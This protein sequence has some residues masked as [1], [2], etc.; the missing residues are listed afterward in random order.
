M[1]GCCSVR[2]ARSSI[3]YSL[4]EAR[5]SWHNSAL[6]RTAKRLAPLGARSTER[7]AAKLLHPNPSER[8]HGVL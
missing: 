3:E 8:A 2:L 5:A 6:E 1:R 7:Y 4:R